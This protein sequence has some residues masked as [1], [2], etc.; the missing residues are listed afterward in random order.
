VGRKN[1][2]ANKLES[3]ISSTEDLS[4][5]EQNVEAAKDRPQKAVWGQP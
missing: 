4:F 2:K 5:P 1:E 3:K